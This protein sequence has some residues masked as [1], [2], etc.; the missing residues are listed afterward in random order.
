MLPEEKAS[1]GRVVREV[2]DDDLTTKLVRKRIYEAADRFQRDVSHWHEKRNE[3]GAKAAG[4]EPLDPLHPFIDTH[5]LLDCES[6]RTRWPKEVPEAIRLAV[7]VALLAAWVDKEDGRTGSH[8]LALFPDDDTHF[9]RAVMKRDHFAEQALALSDARL[10]AMAS[11]VDR[12]IPK[13]FADARPKNSPPAHVPRERWGGLPGVRDRLFRACREGYELAHEVEQLEKACSKR[14]NGVNRD[15]FYVPS[16]MVTGRELHDLIDDTEWPPHERL[17]RRAAIE[18]VLS[19]RAAIDE[20]ILAVSSDGHVMDSPTD[21]PDRRWTVQTIGHLR[22]MRGAI[23]R[24]HDATDAVPSALPMIRAGVPSALREHADAVAVRMEQLKSVLMAGP[25]SK[26]AQSS[27]SE[28]VVSHLVEMKKVLARL[29][30]HHPD[31]DSKD[32]S[33]PVA[34]PSGWTKG[35]LVEQAKLDEARFS[36]SAFD[37]I[38]KAAG[39]KPSPR[40]GK[41][42]QRR[43]SLSELRKMILAVNKSTCRDKAKIIA[44]WKQLLPSDPPTST[45]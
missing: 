24:G 18:A 37:R 45:K 39:V 2:L 8:L 40:G 27:V 33:K 21:G 11:H 31:Q 35:E 36:P 23:L 6:R 10:L 44:A 42:Q 22:K 7:S 26:A 12:L 20:A 14:P 38:R 15:H 19:L 17:A 25:S 1:I 13:L 30:E 32:L 4:P 28:E 3:Q 16:T 5:E 9:M 29:G 41:G 34:K 43:F